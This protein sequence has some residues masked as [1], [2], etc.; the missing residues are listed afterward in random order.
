M[1]NDAVMVVTPQEWQNIIPDAPYIK[2]TLRIN[3]SWVRS[4]FVDTSAN[5][6][7]IETIAKVVGKENIVV[8]AGAFT[9]FKIKLTTYHHNP[10]YTIDNGY[11]YF[12]HNVGLVLKE[13]D[14]VVY[15][16]NSSTNST[17]NYRIIIRT[18][19]VSYHFVQ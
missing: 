19:L 15:Q 8:S 1:A 14:M 4:K 11:E 18:E 13:L 5:K 6:E 12:V 7:S 9:A 16:W 3:D 2:N 10:D 17:I